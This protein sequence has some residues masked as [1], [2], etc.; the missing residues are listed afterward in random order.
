M[1]VQVYQRVDERWAWRAIASNGQI[2]ATDGGQGYE[3]RSD[4]AAMVKKI[5]NRPRMI[6][7]AYRPLHEE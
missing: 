4:C 5:F 1:K 3:N 6:S 7:L 2:V